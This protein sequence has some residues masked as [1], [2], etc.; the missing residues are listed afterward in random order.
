MKLG[1][2]PCQ[3]SMPV[4][5]FIH[6]LL[7]II[8]TS[9]LHTPLTQLAHGLPTPLTDPAGEVGVSI[10]STPT[11]DNQ[12][13]PEGTAE[14][15]VPT[16]GSSS[17]QNL[18]Q[19][20]G[21]VEAVVPTLLGTE[22]PRIEKPTNQSEGDAFEFK[23]TSASDVSA[24]RSRDPVERTADG[25]RMESGD[26][27]TT[28]PPGL[29]STSWSDV[30]ESGTGGGF[31][32]SEGTLNDGKEVGEIPSDPRCLALCMINCTSKKVSEVTID[33]CL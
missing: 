29:L 3:G 1:R 2:G 9:C 4:P 32:I 19:P 8:T 24:A 13:Q 6:I 18:P 16:L 27:G 26:S 17:T 7:I 25:A 10:T 28:L 15:G 30:I 11:P 21:T 22:A 5:S 12:T 33:F 14:T 20:E 31:N 23:G